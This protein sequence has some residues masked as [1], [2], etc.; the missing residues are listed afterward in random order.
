MG[1]INLYLC[2]IYLLLAAA[3]IFGMIKLEQGV[4]FAMTSGAL[5]LCI[6]PLFKRTIC[7]D[8]FYIFA[9][10]LLL[11]FPLINNSNI[12]A[13]GFDGNTW[14]LL[15]LSVTFLSNYISKN[16]ND[17]AELQKRNKDL[18]QMIEELKKIKDKNIDDKK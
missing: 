6:A 15:S 8:L 9:L 5:F 3:N 12:I 7:K 1:N 16:N 10:G 18:L 17:K 13:Y 11:V 2:I 4:I 14:M